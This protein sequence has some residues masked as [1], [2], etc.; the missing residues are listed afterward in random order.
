MPELVQFSPDGEA[1]TVRYHFLAPLLLSEVQK[2]SQTIHELEHTI[3]SQRQQFEQTVSAQVEQLKALQA[4][5]EALE[6]KT[7]K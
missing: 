2:Q 3:D 6:Q 4:R 7:A 5:L 1:Q